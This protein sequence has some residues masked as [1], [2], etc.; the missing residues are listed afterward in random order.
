VEQHRPRKSAKED[1]GEIRY[2]SSP[3]F[4]KITRTDPISVRHFASLD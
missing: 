3:T 2:N 1:R 4:H